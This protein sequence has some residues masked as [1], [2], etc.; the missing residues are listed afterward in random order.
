MRHFDLLILVNR[1]RQDVYD[2]LA[3][4]LNLLEVQPLLRKI[5]TKER[6]RNE[7]GAT[8][9]SFDGLYV[10]PVLGLPLLR[11]LAHVVNTLT[12]PPNE[13]EYHAVYRPRIEIQ[14]AYEFRQERNATQI[15]LRVN[16]IKVSH[17]ME[18]FVYNRAM[19]AQRSLLVNLKNRLEGPV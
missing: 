6:S 15:K 8:V 16:I 5:Q 17:W 2:Y 12:N 13:M 1:P 9:V 10:L 4:P 19:N 7:N 18:D 11:R 14:F 3:D